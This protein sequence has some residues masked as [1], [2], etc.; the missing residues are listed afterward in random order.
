MMELASGEQYEV[1]DGYR[2]Y[3]GGIWCEVVKNGN[4]VFD[5]N[6]EEGMTCEDV[7]RILKESESM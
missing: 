5:G 3:I 7:Y 4:H 2:I 6:V 1:I